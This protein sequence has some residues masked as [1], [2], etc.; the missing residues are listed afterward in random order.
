MKRFI[1]AM[2]LAIGLIGCQPAQAA[3]SD[4]CYDAVIT[5]YVAPD[6]EEHANQMGKDMLVSLWHQGYRVNLREAKEVGEKF[7]EL[8]LIHPN[9]SFDEVAKIYVSRDLL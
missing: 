8:C 2:L 9:K 5:S 1:V 6:A 7:G 3:S 4:N